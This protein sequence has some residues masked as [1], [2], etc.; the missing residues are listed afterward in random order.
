MPVASDVLRNEIIQL[1][2]PAREPWDLALAP[3]RQSARQSN[4]ASVFDSRAQC[5]EIGGRGKIVRI[6]EEWRIH[7]GGRN[8]YASTTLWPDTANAAPTTLPAPDLP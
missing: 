2:F 5:R 7:I 3:V 8:S 6:D 1:T 4:R